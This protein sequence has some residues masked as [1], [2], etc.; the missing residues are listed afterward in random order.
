M[1]NPQRPNRPT[2]IYFVQ[3]SSGPIKIGISIEPHTRI[4]KIQTDTPDEVR[5]I[6]QFSGG[7]ICERGW[8]KTFAASRISGEWFAP[9]EPLLRA[10][11]AV[12]KEPYDWVAALH[13]DWAEARL[14]RMGPLAENLAQGLG[15]ESYQQGVGP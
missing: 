7:V 12:T 9:V 2:Y 1:Q 10:I 11:S 13:E 3:V 8:H 14:R 15:L 5:L 6:G 4:S